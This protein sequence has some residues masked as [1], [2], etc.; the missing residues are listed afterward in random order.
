MKLIETLEEPAQPA[1]TQEEMIALF[2]TQKTDLYKKIGT[3]F[4]RKAKV[5][6]HISTEIDGE[7]E[8]TN[9]AKENDVIMKG[10]KG[11]LYI[12]STAKFKSRYEDTDKLSDEF[13]E[14]VAT[15]LIRA[16]QYKANHF[17]IKFIASWGE[18]MI[19]KEGDYLAT[20]V[21]NETDE[22]VEEVYRIESS[23]FSITYK[24]I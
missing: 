14:F 22:N 24:K 8:T 3:A 11:E 10:P 9:T 15:G 4:A 2:K 19:C 6:E 7:V 5:G 1:K 16:Y 21:K 12:V 13:T 20:T 17:S 18:E 23:V